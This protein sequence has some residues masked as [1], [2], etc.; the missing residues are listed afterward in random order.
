VVV[1]F[2]PL[3][4]RVPPYHRV[5]MEEV[6]KE[7]IKVSWEIKKDYEQTV[8]TW[9]KPP[10]FKAFITVSE[11][12]AQSR[13]ATEDKVYIYVDLGTKPHTIVGSQLVIGGSAFVEGMLQWREG[14]KRKTQ[15]RVLTSTSGGPA[16]GRWRR[17]HQVSHPGIKA[18]EFTAMLTEKYGKE[19]PRRIYNAVRRGLRR[20]RT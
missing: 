3:R 8:K 10:K 6:K 4:P 5:V 1:T 14:Y 11:T 18:R 12:K 2:R 7:A 15:K 13:V 20:A 16:T 19:Y 17:K 9:S